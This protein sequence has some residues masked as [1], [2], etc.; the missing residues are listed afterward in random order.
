MRNPGNL[1]SRKSRR[2]PGLSSRSWMAPQLAESRTAR[3]RRKERCTRALRE[4]YRTVPGLY[5]K[6]QL[7]R[8]KRAQERCRMAQQAHYRMA[9]G[10]H[11]MVQLVH[12]RKVRELHK[13]AQRGRYKMVRGLHK[14]AQ[15]G[16]C[17][18]V[19]GLHRRAQEL[20]MTVQL[21]LHRT[22][23]GLHRCPQWVHQ[24]ANRRNPKPHRKGRVPRRRA[25]LAPG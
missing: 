3:S 20:R 25:Q 21:E 24:L 18:K 14:R 23:L 22:A 5:R 6:V 7:V 4:R 13:R 9:L 19:R 1:G 2:I 11:K 10:L 16:H 15:Q 17:K 12:Y 8:C